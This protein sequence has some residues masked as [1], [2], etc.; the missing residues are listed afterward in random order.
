LRALF[1]SLG[2]A[3]RDALSLKSPAFRALKLDAEKMSDAKIIALMIQ[4]PRL[5]KR[6]LIVIDG[7]P[8]LGFD[9]EAVRRAI[10]RVGEVRQVE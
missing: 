3:P 6:P 4:E 8:I 9:A 2:I 7:K 10:G 1:K 5:I